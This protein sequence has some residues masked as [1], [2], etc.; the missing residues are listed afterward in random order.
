MG[1]FDYIYPTRYDLAMSWVL[2]DYFPLNISY[3]QALRQSTR[4]MGA[5]FHQTS[6]ESH[7]DIIGICMDMRLAH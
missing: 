5:P 3:F 1:M 2:E 6:R 7:G 4:A